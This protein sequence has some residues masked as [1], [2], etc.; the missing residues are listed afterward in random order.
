MYEMIEY[1]M[2]GFFLGYAA[3]YLLPKLLDRYLE[4]WDGGHR[5]DKDG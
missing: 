2:A 1:A 3:A 4:Y 5:E